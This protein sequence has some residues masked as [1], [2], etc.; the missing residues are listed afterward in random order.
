MGMKQFLQG[1]WVMVFNTTFY[2]ISI[3]SWRSV[4]L[5]EKTGVPGENHCP[6]ASHQQLSAHNVVSCTPR[7]SGIRIRNVSGARN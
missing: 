1:L 2:T 4:L 5:V 3:I 7:M 6:A